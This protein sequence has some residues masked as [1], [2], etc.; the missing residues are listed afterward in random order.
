MR[1]P[2]RGSSPKLQKMIRTQATSVGSVWRFATICILLGLAGATSVAVAAEQSAPDRAAPAA[3]PAQEWEVVDDADDDDGMEDEPSEFDDDDDGDGILDTEEDSDDDGVADA[4]DPDYYEPREEMP[5]IRLKAADESGPISEGADTPFSI[6]GVIALDRQ[7]PWQAEIYGPFIDAS[8]DKEA[9]K[10]QQLWQKQHV[11]GGSLLT[12]EWV[13]TAA[14]CIS[15]KMVDQG[16]RIKLGA[17]DISKDPG[18]TYR[19]DRI[20]RHAGFDNMFRND[21]ALVHIV[22]DDKTKPSND[23]RQISAITLYFRSL[24]PGTEVM[25]SGWGRVITS[26]DKVRQGNDVA[27][28][29]DGNLPNAA[30]LRVDLAVVGNDKCR[31]LPGYDPVVLANGETQ[32]RVHPGVICATKPGKAT[33]R[34]DSG[35]PLV[36]YVDRDAFL[37]GIVSWGKGRCTGDGQPGVYTAVASY[38]DWLRR[39]MAVTDPMVSEIQ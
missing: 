6:G 15:K 9:T 23:P 32:P 37:V 18:V 2:R 13:L 5:V 19:I 4:E 12:V 20:V 29:A 25:A 14:H 34:G 21:I 38:R 11:C 27:F 35:G 24:H 1:S 10:G 3:A 30:L 8:F 26:N 33:C 31:K 17:E 16:W 36:V 7:V 28:A 22:P 39:A